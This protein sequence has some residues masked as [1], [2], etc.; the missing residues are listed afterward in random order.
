M[1]EQA[2]GLLSRFGFAFACRC[3]F[4]RFDHKD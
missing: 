4:L 2:P 3:G 1:R